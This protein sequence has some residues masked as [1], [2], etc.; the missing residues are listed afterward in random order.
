MTTFAIYQIQDQDIR[1]NSWVTLKPTYELVLKHSSDY[2]LVARIDSWNDSL[3][4]VF[5]ISNSGEHESLIER[6]ED[7]HSLSVGDVV[8][9]T[10]TGEA[11]F[12]DMVGF[13]PCS[14]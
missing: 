4:N 3:E 2:K 7:M 8:K 13:K 5:L 12:V 14:I 1:R 9:N 10:E 11:F 6:I